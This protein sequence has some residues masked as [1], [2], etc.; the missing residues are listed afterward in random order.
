MTPM[1]NFVS[2]GNIE[3]FLSKLWSTWSV[4]ERDTLFRLVAAEETQMATSRQHTL[5]NGRRIADCEN[6]LEQQRRIVEA[7]EREQRDASRARFALRTFERTLALLNDHQKM[8][9][10]RFE[11]AKL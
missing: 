5:E 3:I 2:E 10:S 4:D 7:L 8:L 1:D 9:Q 6:R 11:R